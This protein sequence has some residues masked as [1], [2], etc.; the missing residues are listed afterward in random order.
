MRDITER[1]ALILICRDA[2]HAA[3]HSG[4]AHAAVEQMLCGVAQYDRQHAPY[5]SEDGREAH[6]RADSAPKRRKES[7]SA[8]RRSA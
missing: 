3:A 8:E 2:I 5:Y 4:N 7:I 1:E 6:Q